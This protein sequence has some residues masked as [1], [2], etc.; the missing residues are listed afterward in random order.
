MNVDP[1]VW[2]GDEGRVNCRRSACRAAAVAIAVA[3]AAPLAV[4]AAV[5]VAANTLIN[6]I[7]A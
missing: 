4:A 1:R 7:A 5:V 6:L 3:V 2:A